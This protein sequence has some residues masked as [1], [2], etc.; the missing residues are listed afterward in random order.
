MSVCVYMIM[1]KDRL[2]LSFTTMAVVYE[3]QVVTMIIVF[4]QI[5]QLNRERKEAEIGKPA[6]VV[7]EERARLRKA[8]KQNRVILYVMTILVAIFSPFIMPILDP[9][10]PSWTY[11]YSVIG[12]LIIGYVTVWF[13]TS[14]RLKELE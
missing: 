6:E 12:T 7:V 14:K 8:I 2:Q 3:L 11:P 1:L 13:S 9:E 10:L 5:K 4:W